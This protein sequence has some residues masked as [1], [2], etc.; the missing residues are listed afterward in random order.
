MRTVVDIAWMAGLFEGEG[1]CFLKKSSP[2][3]E[4]NVPYAKISMT[5]EDVIRHFHLL[6]GFGT[7]YSSALKSGSACFT[8]QSQD[9]VKVPELLREILPFLGSR[10]S[11]RISEVL[12]GSKLYGYDH[13]SK[14]KSE[15]NLVG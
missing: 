15:W 6:A 12:S 5:D 14:P 8:W 10:R 11:E 2:T 13:R 3:G 1:S 7:V 9:R 4:R